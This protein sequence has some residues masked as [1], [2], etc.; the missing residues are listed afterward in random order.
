[1]S[2][3]AYEAALK[4]VVRWD[5][6][7]EEWSDLVP[8]TAQQLYFGSDNPMER[9]QFADL[10]ANFTGRAVVL[11]HSAFITKVKCAPKSI[12]VT[13]ANDAA[14][15]MIETEW[16]AVDDF[17][18]VTNSDSCGYLSEQFSFWDVKTLKFS[19]QTLTVQVSVDRGST[20]AVYL[21]TSTCPGARGSLAHPFAIRAA[22]L[23]DIVW[24]VVASGMSPGIALSEGAQLALQYHPGIVVTKLI[25]GKALEFWQPD[26]KL[27]I[28]IDV[29]FP[30][31]KIDASAPAPSKW[32]NPGVLKKINKGET[33]KN[34]KI[35]GSVGLYCVDCHLAGKINVEGRAEFTSDGGISALYAGA[36][37][38]FQG[39]FAIG[40]A[41][42]VKIDYEEKIDI[43]EAAI[44]YCG[45]VVDNVISVGATVDLKAQF[46][47]HLHAT[48]DI[49]VGS[50]K[51]TIDPVWTP[52]LDASAKITVEAGVS[53]PVAIGLSVTIPILKDK[54]K[55]KVQLVEQPGVN[56]M[57]EYKTSTPTQPDPTDPDGEGNPDEE[58][59]DQGGDGNNEGDSEH[60][61]QDD[62]QNNRR[63]LI[64]V[65]EG[66]PECDNGIKWSVKFNNKVYAEALF[67]SS[68]KDFELHTYSKEVAGGCFKVGG[69]KTRAQ[70]WDPTDF[71]TVN[72]VDDEYNAAENAEDIKLLDG[73]IAAVQAAKLD[74]SDYPDDVDFLVIQDFSKQFQ[75]LQDKDGYLQPGLATTRPVPGS[76]WAEKDGSVWADYHHRELKFD[77]KSMKANGWSNIQLGPIGAKSS[78]AESILLVPAKTG[79]PAKPYIYLA[80]DFKR[81]VYVLLT[82]QYT[83]GGGRIFLARNP[84]MAAKTLQLANTRT[85]GG[86]VKGCVAQQWIVKPEDVDVWGG[87]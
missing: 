85:T 25:A 66:E 19:P 11:Q 60:E 2:M 76:I 83:T 35:E 7:L 6:N 84:S 62:G 63:A 82:C 38:D 44:P 49:V 52:F 78:D 21:V 64:L 24:C 15:S 32:K 53:F 51:P 48:G 3:E 69:L 28:P 41:A 80:E 12:E 55:F 57:A 58:G 9:H 70:T 34:T 43:F 26:M 86:R 73:A 77:P 40:L 8:Q 81:N 4:P 33:I 30:E 27:S 37:A 13:L 47:A 20:L 46:E 14:Y 59:S 74:Y 10:T 61:G 45:F 39:Q 71:D 36:D 67:A 87:R 29:R 17:M 23:R 72:D 5:R 1:M 54:G 79:I 22:R 16:Q 56:A 50:I 31:K 18:L 68:S 65:R 42:E 75:I